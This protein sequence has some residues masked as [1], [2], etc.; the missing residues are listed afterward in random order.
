[1]AIFRSSQSIGIDVSDRM[2][3]LVAVND[4][5]RKLQL[6]AF[7]EI[8]VPPGVI[9]NGGIQKPSEMV[10]LLKQLPKEVMGS[11]SPEMNVNIGLPEHHSFVTVLKVNEVNRDTI[12]QLADTVLPFEPEE[13][14]YESEPI[15]GQRAVSLVAGRKKFIDGFLEIME[16]ANIKPVG[17]YVESIAI[18]KALVP[19]AQDS[20]VATMLL[21]VGSARTTVAIHANSAVYFTT[22]YPPVF[23][24]RSFNQAD[25]ANVLTQVVHYYQTHFS[26][27]PPLQKIVV[28]GS[29]SYITGM[30]EMIIQSS[31]IAT[32]YGNPLQLF[33]RTSL[34]KKM[35]TPLAFTTAIG[36][37][38]M[39]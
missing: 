17:L 24:E 9:L 29:G 31:G 32:E 35:K 30:A 23:N 16:A 15:K 34:L 20:T 39:P 18:A 8:A 26:E 38:L 36:L 27:Q 11:L 12:T 19:H 14:Y 7:G 2:I 6:Q 13:I 22:S 1:M 10:Q 4:S 33:K 28:C 5:G 37:A 21:D 3:R 25:L